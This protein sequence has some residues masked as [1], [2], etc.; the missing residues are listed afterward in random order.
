[1]TTAADTERRRRAI[2]ALRMVVD[3]SAG[4]RRVLRA[5]LA[6]EDWRVR[7]TAA[8]VAAARALAWRLLPDLVAALGQSDDVGLRNAAVEACERLGRH[9]DAGASALL[10][11]IQRALPEATTTA[12][13]FLTAALAFAGPAAATALVPL[14]EDPDANTAQAALEALGKVGGPAAEAALLPFLGHADPV[15]RLSALQGLLDLEAKVPAARLLPLLSDPLVRRGAVR[16]LGRSDDPAAVEGLFACLQH[17]RLA[18]DVA[19]ALLALADGPAAEAVRARASAPWSTAAREALRPLLTD[20]GPPGQAATVLLLLARD[21]AALARVPYWANA[22]GLP[23]LGREALR[24][25]SGD[26]VEPLLAFEGSSPERAVALE[27]ALDLARADPRRRAAVDAAL[28]EAVQDPDPQ[29]ADAAAALLAQKAGP[30]DAA[31]LI[32]LAQ[33]RAQ[34]VDPPVTAALERLAHE[35]PEALS[36]ALEEAGAGTLPSLLPAFA[37]LGTPA[38]RESVLAGLNDGDPVLRRAAVESLVALPSEEALELAAFALADEAVPVQLAAVRTLARVAAGPSRRG[39]EALRVALAQAGAPSVQAEA[40]HALGRLGGFED[41]LWELAVSG[42]PLAALAA[43]T[44]LPRQEEG[45]WAEVL[46]RSDEDFVEAAR[47][48]REEDR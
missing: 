39:T 27:L 40:A 7:K 8:A 3:P 32:E 31:T 24:R 28:R 29:L 42:P 35:A 36:P 30:A 5:A 26:A 33:R 9:D 43:L 2:E 1:V 13:H 15:R 4:D 46:A 11:A 14:L 12:R 16:L 41:A 37:A 48:L 19:V 10:D 47:A 38:S 21:D 34:H 22:T 44:H 45:R 25:L 17:P 18:Q 20:R 6:D 23:E